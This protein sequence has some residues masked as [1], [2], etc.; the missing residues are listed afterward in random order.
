MQL[1]KTCTGEPELIH[2]LKLFDG[3]VVRAALVRLDV[4]SRR[5]VPWG[6][7]LDQANST[8]RPLQGRRIVIT[9]AREQS[10]ELR[11]KLAALGAA[12]IEL[13]LIEIVAAVESGVGDEIFSEIPSYQWLVFTSPNGVRF[14]FSEFFRRFRDIRALGGARLA[15]VGAGTAKELNAL[16][17]DVDVMPT[18]H[19]GEALVE[20]LC[21]FESVENLKVL[22]VTGDRNRDVV[23]NGLTEQ[24]AIVDHLPVY[25]TED[26]DAGGSDAAAD[27]RQQGAD[28]ILFASGSAVESFVKQ[29]STLAPRPGAKR[30]LTGSLGPVTS[31]VMRRSGLP[32]DFEAADTTMDALVAAVVKKL[33]M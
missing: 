3:S 24:R 23:V 9:R 11:D 28:V 2:G 4:R 15:V 26:A 19:V 33:G 27:F 16:H 31:N 13:P 10:G 29:A 6:M 14:F 12:V 30:P 18:E 1:G 5:P 25:A 21:A 7:S 20:A 22:V 32:V 8:S 17:L